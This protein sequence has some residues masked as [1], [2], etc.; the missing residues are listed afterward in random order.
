MDVK[1]NV[2]KYINILFESRKVF[3]TSH[4]SL[5][6]RLLLFL[7]IDTIYDW[8]SLSPVTCSRVKQSFLDV[9]GFCVSGSTYIEFVV[10]MFLCNISDS[11]GM[12]HEEYCFVTFIL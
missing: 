7:L 5:A 6:K 8:L 11:F 2:K 4:F 10:Y 3:Y 1:N 9:G 12:F